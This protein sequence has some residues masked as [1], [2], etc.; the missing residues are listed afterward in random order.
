MKAA[1]VILV[2]IVLLA[3]AVP[4]YG[5]FNLCYPHTAHGIC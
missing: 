4:L 3:I 1:M 2:C 5:Y